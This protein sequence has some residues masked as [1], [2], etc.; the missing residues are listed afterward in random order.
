MPS[1]AEQVECVLNVLRDWAEQDP[2]IVAMALVG[3]WASGRARDDSDVDVI[4][5]VNEPSNFRAT[6]DWLRVI[7]WR[8][9]RLSVREW[10]DADYGA[11]W[12]RHL[13]CEPALEVELSFAEPS[14]AA[15]D[16]VDPG[17]AR[18]V[19][20]GCRVIYDPRGHLSKL[21]SAL[22]A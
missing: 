14:W 15:F 16:P 7:A 12:S 10:V 13:S 22:R 19:R 21:T 17:T 5:L 20:R 4:V 2:D 11:V 9:A 6:E 3:S 8:D 18:V 1:R